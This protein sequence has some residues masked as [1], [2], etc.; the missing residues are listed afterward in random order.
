M[1]TR[2]LPDQVGDLPR[3]GRPA[4]AALLERGVTSLEQVA[5]MSERQLLALHGVGPRAVR[6]LR[7]ALAE[8]ERDLTE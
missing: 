1:S 6:L 5:A 2:D 8:Q 7:E 4:T 3:I